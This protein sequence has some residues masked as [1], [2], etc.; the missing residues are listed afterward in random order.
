VAEIFLIKSCAFSG[1][2][3]LIGEK[4]FICF[5]SIS[6]ALLYQE[7]LCNLELIKR[8]FGVWYRI[9]QLLRLKTPNPIA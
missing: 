1:F 3:E 9:K 4:D 5:G 7:I 2:R 6:R 8:Y